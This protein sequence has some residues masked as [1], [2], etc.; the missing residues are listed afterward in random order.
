M[1]HFTMDNTQGY[2]QDDL[3]QL[4]RELNALLADVEPYTSEWYEVSK[5]FAD[6]VANR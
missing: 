3:D 2:N 1:D 6:S 5:R 4:N